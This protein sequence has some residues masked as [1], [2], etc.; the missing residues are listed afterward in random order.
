LDED[1]AD[2]EEAEHR[3]L[4][5]VQRQLEPAVVAA[6][7]YTASDERI[8]KQDVPEREQVRTV[9]AARQTPDVPFLPLRGS[10]AQL[11]AVDEARSNVVRERACRRCVE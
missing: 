7:F 9:A 4:A 8:R 5:R 10:C 1:E 2:G 11:L 6:N 3:M